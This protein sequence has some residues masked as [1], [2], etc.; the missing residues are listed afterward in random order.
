MDHRSRTHLAVLAFLFALLDV[1]LVVV[2]V[3]GGDWAPLWAAGRLAWSNPSAIYDFATVTALQRPILGET[4][5]RPFVYPPSTLLA[6]APFAWLPFYPSLIAFIAVTGAAFARQ[7]LRTGSQWPLLVMPPVALAALVGQTS[8]LVGALAL[9]SIIRMRERPQLAGLLLGLAAAIKPTLFVLAPFA[10]IAG[11]HWR[12]LVYAAAAGIGAVA[13]SALL[14]GLES[15]FAW[16]DALPRFQSLFLDNETLVRTAVSPY[17]LGV[18]YGFTTA[19]IILVCGVI[20]VTG[21]IWTFRS[22][23]D[24]AARSV[25]LLGGALLVSPYAMNYELALLAP[26]IMAIPIRRWRDM[27]V[28]LAFAASL[29]ATA[30]LAGL[31]LAMAVLALR[32][33]KRW[34]SGDQPSVQ[35]RVDVSA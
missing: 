35:H 34:L 10:L 4:V 24:V 18:R 22:T 1:I 6:I 33:N 2:F 32:T 16:F 20:A 8:F 7:A 29:F 27:V 17:A 26:A 15:W 12:T 14:F 11:G 28:P 23:E 9:A 21:A 30:S 5:L 25:A 13:T 31:V 19:W 3:E